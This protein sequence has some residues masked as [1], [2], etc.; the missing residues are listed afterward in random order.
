MPPVPNLHESWSSV[1]FRLC[2]YLSKPRG[3]DSQEEVLMSP[4]D[5]DQ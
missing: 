2:R 3:R 4:P 1:R 5:S